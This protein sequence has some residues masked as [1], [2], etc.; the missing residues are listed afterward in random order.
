MTTTDYLAQF[1]ITMQEA[2]D[3]V[4]ANLEAPAL[5]LSVALQYGV[6]TTM[7]GEIA[8]GYAA[9]D[10]RGFFSEHGLDATPLDGGGV[11]SYNYSM[12]MTPATLVGIAPDLGV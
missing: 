10:V 7:L 8:G 2:H 12:P 9:S 4:F 11:Y 3:F 6:T 5:I 1:G